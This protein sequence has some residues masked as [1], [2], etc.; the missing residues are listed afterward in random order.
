MSKDDDFLLP[1]ASLKAKKVEIKKVV[2]SEFFYKLKMNKISKDFFIKNIQN[3]KK[4]TNNELFILNGYKNNCF[5]FINKL[6]LL[7]KF[8]KILN[9]NS[10]RKCLVPYK[11]D[12]NWESMNKNEILL[13]IYNSMNKFDKIFQKMNILPNIKLY[14]GIK[15][16]GIVNSTT[17]YIKNKK[18]K[19]ENIFKN[20]KEYTKNNILSKIESNKWNVLNMLTGFN[21]DSSL[22]YKEVKKGDI[23]NNEAYQS[24]SI[25]PNVAYNFIR[26]AGKEREIVFL[27]VN[28]KKEDKIPFIFLTNKLLDVQ[29]KKNKKLLNNWNKTKYDEFEILLPRNVQYQVVSKKIYKM[30]REING[31]ENYFT[32]KK[33]Y[34][35][36][37]YVKV[38]SLP[39]KTQSKIKSS[40]FTS[41]PEH[42]LV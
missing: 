20:K 24:T 10:L 18:A 17:N 30:K 40:Y 34:K 26:Y 22:S 15:N 1:S 21:K 39:Y 5:V 25:N 7:H 8:P 36:I 19:C 14:R 28:I 29:S 2:N 27:E 12:K 38:R 3:I 11:K 13:S 37:I 42:L 16:R 35:E 9:T 32:N 31:F 23:L 6:L 33:S 41:F 4:L